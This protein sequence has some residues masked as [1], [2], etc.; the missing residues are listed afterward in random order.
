M[1]VIAFLLVC[2][3]IGEALRVASLPLAQQNNL[4]WLLYFSYAFVDLLFFGIGSLVWLYGYRR[5]PVVASL[6][7][8]FC[9]LIAVV[10]GALSGSAVGDGVF[11][12]IGSSSSALGVLCL[13]F[14]LVR[15]PYDFLAQPRPGRFRFLHMTLFVILVLC[16][17]LVTRSICVHALHIAVPAWVDL[18]GLLYYLLATVALVGIVIYASRHATTIRAQQQTRL[19]FAGVLLSCV[20]ILVLTVVPTLLHLR[21]VVDGTVS[22]FFL[23][24][25]PVTLSY[26]VL[27]Y[28]LLLFDTYVRRTITLIVGTVALALLIYVLFAAGSLLVAER[29]SLLLAGLLIVAVFGAPITWWLAS[30]FTTRYFFPETLHY[31]ALLSQARTRHEQDSFDLQLLAQELLLDVHTTLKTPEACLFFLEN[32]SSC[33]T[34]LSPLPGDE[35]SE[36]IRSFLLQ[37]LASWFV[38]PGD[39][40]SGIAT[41]TSLIEQ[42]RQAQ[43]PVFLSEVSHAMSEPSKGLARYLPLRAPNDEKD[44][45]LLA[46][47]RTPKGMLIGVLVVGER[48]DQQRYAGPEL[49]ALH[50]LVKAHVRSFETALLYQRATWQQARSAQELAEAYAKERQLNDLKEQFIIHMS[51]ELRTPL[52]E[53]SGYLELLG[54]YAGALDVDMQKL[55]IEKA[56]HGCDELLQLLSTVLEAAHSGKAPAVHLESVALAQVVREEIDHLAPQAVQHYTL[57][58][59]I[60]DSLLVQVNIQS[61]RQVV[62]NLLSNALKFSPPQTS[63]TINATAHGGTVCFTVKDEG[64]GV[65]PEEMHLLFGKFVRLSRH[66]SGSIRGSGLGLYISKQLVEAMGGRIWAE[67][68]GIPGEGTTLYVHLEEARALETQE[69]EG[70]QQLLLL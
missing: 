25:F 35:R 66:L 42:V 8:A 11:N 55:F 23:I 63:I 20:P 36:R 5:Q 26:S 21:A 22:M 29:F 68:S 40:Q 4:F 38:E 48:G 67:S 58:E 31:H 65:P 37:P 18:L 69:P 17:I 33:F 28:D 13:L 54:S 53:V 45:L 15:F 70:K 7:M 39:V 44:E 12:A 1:L 62:R 2:Q 49:E 34:L 6:L 59:Q 10:F 61:L 32:E 43:R 16:A 9:S 30:R 52:S 47:V 14:L 51:H 50:Q 19:F 64:P 3:Q 56:M 27:R 60:A 46:P 24:F 57:I 41:S